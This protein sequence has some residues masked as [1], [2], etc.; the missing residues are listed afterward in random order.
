MR[1]LV[2]GSSM[3]GML[4]ASRPRTVEEARKRFLRPIQ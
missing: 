3:V 2:D 4:M 1:T